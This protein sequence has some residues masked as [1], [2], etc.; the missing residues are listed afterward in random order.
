MSVRV[1]VVSCVFADRLFSV[2]A[3]PTFRNYL[4]SLASRRSRRRLEAQTLAQT[5]AL[6][7]FGGGDALGADPLAVGVAH[8]QSLR[9]AAARFALESLA[10]R[11]RPNS[12]HAT[13]AI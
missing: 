11:F 9:R 13:R 2:E 5:F 12:S 1:R 6:V 3:E 8:V 7:N 10:H 4:S